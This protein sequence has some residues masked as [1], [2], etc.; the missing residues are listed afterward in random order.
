[1]RLGAFLFPAVGNALGGAVIA[2]AGCRCAFGRGLGVGA[3]RVRSEEK[4]RRR[5]GSVLL[6][7]AAFAVASLAATTVSGR[8]EGIDWPDVF[9]EAS[10]ALLA[11]AWM[12]LLERATFSSRVFWSFSLGMAV[13]GPAALLDVVDELFVFEG[14]WASIVENAGKVSGTLLLS[15]GLYRWRGEQEARRQ[16]L[17]ASSE[18]WAKLSVTD[19]LTGLFNRAHFFECLEAVAKGKT[20]SVMMLDLD[21]FKEHNDTYGHLEGDKVIVALAEVIG[22]CIRDS[23]VAG[24]YGGEEFAVALVGAEAERA[25]EVAERIR[26]AFEARRFEPVPGDEVQRTVSIGVA[27][28]IAGEDAESL[29]RRADEALFE[30]KNSG[31]NRVCV[32]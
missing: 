17:E 5:R 21:R 25:A 12:G 24:R 7:A 1:M 15:M 14:P 19:G 30:A 4:R 32:G 2:S 27:E 6:M 20:V 10:L 9:G 3:M 8:T 28:R 11:F 29:V 23:D 26:V 31:R 16:E 22:S 18:H 13:L